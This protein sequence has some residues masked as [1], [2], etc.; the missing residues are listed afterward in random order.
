MYGTELWRG[1]EQQSEPRFWDV[2]EQKNGKVSD[3]ANGTKSVR[4]F[5][6]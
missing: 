5:R 6:D 2:S 1:K 3:L 4:G